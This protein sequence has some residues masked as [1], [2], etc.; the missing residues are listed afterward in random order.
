MGGTLQW[1][2]YKGKPHLE[3]GDLVVPLFVETPNTLISKE[4]K[5]QSGTPLNTLA[6]AWTLQRP[7]ECIAIQIKDVL[8]NNYP[9]SPNLSEFYPLVN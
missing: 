4:L 9:K 1:M 8:I 5:G 7:L 2:V 6:A 3:M